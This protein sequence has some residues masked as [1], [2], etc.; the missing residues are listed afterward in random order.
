[1]TDRTGHKGFAQKKTLSVSTAELVM[2]DFDGTAT[3]DVFNIPENVLITNIYTLVEVAGKSGLKL[4]VEVGSVVA[5]A[6]GDVATVGAV[7]KDSYNKLSGTGKLIKVTPSSAVTY[8][9]FVVVVEYIEYTLSN[10]D[11]TSYSSR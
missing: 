4:K 8:G 10:G 3:I 7:T 2:A 1:M 6:S 9:K 11:L 5:I